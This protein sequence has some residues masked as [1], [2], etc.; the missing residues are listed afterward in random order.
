MKTLVRSYSEEQGDFRRITKFITDNYHHF[1]TN[2]TMTL[3]RFV[4]W[5]YGLY[6]SKTSDPAFLENNAT[7]FWQ[8]RNGSS[9]V[10]MR[11]KGKQCK[12]G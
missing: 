2:S 12:I 8:N 7:C 6:S 9:S 3:P 4:D 5:K 10:Y 1:R 11:E